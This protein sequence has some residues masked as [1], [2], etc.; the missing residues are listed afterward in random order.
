[1]TDKL[2][3]RDAYLFA[4]D[5]RVVSCASSGDKFE[6]VLDR[7]AFYP[8]GG[9]QPGD[10]GVIGGVRVLDTVSRGDDVVHICSGPVS[11]RVAARVDGERRLANMRAHTA[12]HIF[13]G[14][15][16]SLYGAENV[17]FHMG[18]EGVT[19]DLDIPLTDEMLRNILLKANGVIMSDAAVT[20]YYPSE[21]ELAG[22]D[23]RSKKEIDGPV[24]IVMVEGA[25][26]CACCGTHLSRAGQAGLLMA[27]RTAPCRGG[28][29]ILL[30]A[31]ADAFEDYYFKNRE[32]SR[33]ASLMSLKED[34]TAD[35]VAAL[36]SK[37]DELKR[38]VRD[39]KDRNFALM[40]EGAQTGAVP[41]VF[42]DGL[43]PADVMR[44][45]D[46]LAEKHG[47]GAVFSGNDGSGYMYAVC[48]RSGGCRELSRSLNAAL[49]GR[50]GGKD[51]GAQGRVNAS[52]RAI[53]EFLYSK[54]F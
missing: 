51:E 32:L 54:S 39:L 21:E 30:K 5:A 53:E 14:C 25:D 31:G 44:F 22:L 10:T 27:V 35:G 34:E 12:E 16:H 1:M 4:F 40:C 8:E 36:N 6:A 47:R 49:N 29:R 11:G 28:T 43:A 23:F 24:R 52:R 13:S 46:M 7:T 41:F 17:G 45:A 50:G 48:S 37:I 15:A 38:E 20:C 33:A 26:V 9:G 2:Y 19:V 3:Y 18:S 42:A